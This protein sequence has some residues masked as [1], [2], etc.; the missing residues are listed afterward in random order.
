MG[1]GFL[2]CPK[3]ILAQQKEKPLKEFLSVAV[4]YLFAFTR[5][6]TQIFAI[7]HFASFCGFAGCIAV[8]NDSGDG[9]FRRI[10]ALSSHSL[11]P[12]FS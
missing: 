12:H 6:R 3:R 9:H 1:K 2:R 4:G 5:A 11:S 7:D 10:A 8:A